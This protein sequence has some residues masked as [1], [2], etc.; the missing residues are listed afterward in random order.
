[1][2]RKAWPTLRPRSG[3]N[4]EGKRSILTQKNQ[5]PGPILRTEN[6]R[7]LTLNSLQRKKNQTPIVISGANILWGYNH[8]VVAHHY[9]MKPS[10]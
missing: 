5:I 2:S 4:S 6:N 3:G 1:V 7:E 10:P 9:K 8:R